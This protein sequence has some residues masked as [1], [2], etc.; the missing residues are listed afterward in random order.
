LR[1][2]DFLILVKEALE[3]VSVLAGTVERKVAFAFKEER[4]A[5]FIGHGPLVWF[6]LKDVLRSRER[7]VEKDMRQRGH[8]L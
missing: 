5:I 7:V 3:E 4:K 8:P 1:V 2:V 6:G